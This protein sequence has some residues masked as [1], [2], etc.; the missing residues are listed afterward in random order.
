MNHLRATICERVAE[1]KASWCKVLVDLADGVSVPGYALEQLPGFDPEYELEP[2][3]CYRLSNNGPTMH[4]AAV[5]GRLAAE[6]DT[7]PDTTLSN[8][9]WLADAVHF[10]MSVVESLGRGEKPTDA[11]RHFAWQLGMQADFAAGL[12]AVG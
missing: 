7:D 6:V 12:R 9:I 8:A 2:G 1:R 5:A 4:L 11:F 10:H 3:D